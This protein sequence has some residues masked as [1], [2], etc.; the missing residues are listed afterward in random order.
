MINEL[1]VREKKSWN[2]LLRILSDGDGQVLQG[3][4]PATSDRPQEDTDSGSSNIGPLDLIQHILRRHL[5][6]TDHEFVAVSLWIMHSFLFDRFSISP[7]LVVASPVRGCG[8]T[9][10]LSIIANLAHKPLKADH[11]TAAS[12]FRLV[13]SKHP[14]LL[15]DEADNLGLLD[16]ATLRAVM[17]SGHRRG[18]KVVRSIGCEVAE[19]ATFAPMALAVI[20]KLPRPLLHRSIV[21]RMERSPAAVSLERFDELIEKQKED[22]NVVYRQIFDWAV[23]CRLN[24][25]PPMPEALHNRRADNWRILIAIA[26]AC[27]PTWAKIAREAAVALSEAH[28]DEDF[29]VRLL[30]DIRDIFDCRPAADRLASAVLV[31]QLCDLPDG[32]WAEWRGLRDDQTQRR[33][34]QGELARLL[35]S[36]NIRPRTIWPPRRGTRDRSAKGYFRAQFEL[37]WASY[38]DAAGTPSQP[39]NIRYLRG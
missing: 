12:V 13:D 37:A 30:A 11:I 39:S 16:N 17:N 29:G 5:H 24:P 7:R 35:A 25:D 6:L 9:T 34:S 26:D 23:R 33:L 18:G 3:Q 28:Q 4:T 14:T 27:G 8:K 21:I 38:C 2:D 36:F 10:A 31:A 1:L 32:L 19:F 22:C 20:G 15:L